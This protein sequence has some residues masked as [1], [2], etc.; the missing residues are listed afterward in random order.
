[1]NGG[2]VTY[3]AGT[4]GNITGLTPG[5]TYTVVFYNTTT[6]LPDATL[7]SSDYFVLEDASGTVMHISQGTALGTHTF[8]DATNGV[9]ASVTLASISADGQTINLADHG[10]T[11]SVG[12]PQ[13]LNYEA[14]AGAGIGGLTDGGQ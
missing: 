3:Q 14:L 4:D 9:S 2:T 5:A 8:T 13:A 10:F 1:V 12:S 6:N 7:T 11:G